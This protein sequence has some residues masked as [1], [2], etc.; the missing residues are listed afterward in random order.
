MPSQMP[1][2]GNV[3]T[4]N[5]PNMIL[6]D[7]L[8][9]VVVDFLPMVERLSARRVSRQWHSVLDPGGRWDD[10]KTGKRSFTLPCRGEVLEGEVEKDGGFSITVKR[11]EWR[12]TCT[13]MS[14]LEFRFNIRQRFCLEE[15]H[16]HGNKHAYNARIVQASDGGISSNPVMIKGLTTA[17]VDFIY[18]IVNEF[19]RRYTPKLT[20]PAFSGRC[21]TRR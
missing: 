14:P 10:H 16:I 3:R 20:G 6:N 12:L 1:S 8:L 21:I 17:E 9:R 13:M 2:E 18:M 11:L 19:S 15:L 4:I 7:D 5:Q